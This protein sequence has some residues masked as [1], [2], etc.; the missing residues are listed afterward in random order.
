MTYCA[1]RVLEPTFCNSGA[2]FLVIMLSGL[3]GAIN[4]PMHICECGISPREIGAPQYK[5]FNG[6][7]RIKMPD[8]APIQVG[9]FPYSMEI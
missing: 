5:C 6:V 4:L 7:R 8:G 9:S 1:Q 3:P 2:S